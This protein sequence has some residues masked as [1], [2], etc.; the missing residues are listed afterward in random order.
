M[1]FFSIFSPTGSYFVW[2]WKASWIFYSH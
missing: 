2:Q 1:N